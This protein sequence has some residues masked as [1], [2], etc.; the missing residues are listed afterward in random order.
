MDSTG[1]MTHAIIEDIRVKGDAGIEAFVRHFGPKL[2][3]RG[4]GRVADEP[5][6]SWGVH[7]VQVYWAVADAVEEV[8]ETI[9]E[10]VTDFAEMTGFTEFIIEPVMSGDE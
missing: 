6:W 1:R 9:L 3:R 5:G 8:K 10:P 7:N 2:L 4:G